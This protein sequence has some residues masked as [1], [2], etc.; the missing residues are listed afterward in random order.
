M[1]PLPAGADREL[2]VRLCRGD[3]PAAT[4]RF[5]RNGE[6]I[7]EMTKGT[8]IS[9]SPPEMIFSSISGI[10]FF[11]FFFFLR[12]CTRDEIAPLLL[13]R[14]LLEELRIVYGFDN[15]LFFGGEGLLALS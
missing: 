7:D 4:I 10:S 3:T 9:T 2:H 1:V 11:A 8:R 13:F 14:F 6:E 15:F 12:A 5:E